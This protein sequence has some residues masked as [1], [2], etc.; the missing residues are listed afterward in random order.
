M[1]EWS[2]KFREFKKKET[3]S[4]LF[5]GGSLFFNL[6]FFLNQYYKFKLKKDK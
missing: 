2:K 4:I 1:K 3:K 6:V 5:I